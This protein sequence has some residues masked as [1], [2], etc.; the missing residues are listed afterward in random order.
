MAKMFYTLEEAASALGVNVEDVKTLAGSGK[1]QQFRDRD[2]LMFKRDEV[3]ALAAK[4]GSDANSSSGTIPLADSQDTDNIDS[5]QDTAQLSTD[6]TGLLPADSASGTNISIG[7]GV[8]V[9]ETG[10][11]DAADPLAQTQAMPAGSLSQDAELS[12]DSIGSGSGL[13]DLTR[14]RDDTSL[15]V[16]IDEI[17]PHDSAQSSGLHDSLAG[18]GTG[19]GT[20]AGTAAGSLA[21]ASAILEEIAADAEGGEGAQSPAGAVMISGAQEIYDGPGSGLVAGLMLGSL[22]VLVVCLLVALSGLTESPL[23]VTAALGGSTSTV[24]IA[25]VAFLAVSGI[26]GGIGWVLGKKG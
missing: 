9:F 23:A 17:M 22:A 12:L 11:V 5:L 7:S 8:N 13:L 19:A 15:G 6:E 16:E 2:K 14:E 24:L 10:E 18:S 26:M 3:D 25:A 4:T 1:L 21:A 20:A